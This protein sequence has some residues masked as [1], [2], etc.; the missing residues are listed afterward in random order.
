MAASELEDMAQKA[1]EAAKAAQTSAK[2]MMGKVMAAVSKQVEGKD[3]DKRTL[4]EIVKKV[5]S[6][7]NA[8]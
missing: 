5:I 2:E 7:S 6:G 1:V 4:A 8:S 3:V